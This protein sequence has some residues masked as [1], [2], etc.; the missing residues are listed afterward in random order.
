MEVYIPYI[1]S[2][3]SAKEKH[4]VANHA[5]KELMWLRKLQ[6]YVRL[7]QPNPTILGC[8]HQSFI[9]MAKNTRFHARIK[10]I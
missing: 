6:K 3:S 5:R 1:L 2:V 10:S 9:E 8:D 4:V 7:E